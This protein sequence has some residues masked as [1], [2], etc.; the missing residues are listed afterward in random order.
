MIW[1]TCIPGSGAS[2]FQD[3]MATN[4]CIKKGICMFGIPWL[5]F[6]GWCC[7][8]RRQQLSF[9]LHVTKLYDMLI[10]TYETLSKC[11]IFA[12]NA[13]EILSF[14]F[15]GWGPYRFTASGTSLHHPYLSSCERQKPYRVCSYRHTRQCRPACHQMIVALLAGSS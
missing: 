3:H 9:L 11:I 1:T 2:T 7:D 8:A 12:W 13:I 5:Y 15:G 14:F 10:S 4:N 6:C